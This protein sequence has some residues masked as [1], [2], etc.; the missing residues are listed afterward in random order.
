MSRSNETGRRHIAVSLAAA[1]LVVAGIGGVAALSVARDSH[2]H[3]AVANVSGGRTAEARE[4]LPL[5]VVVGRMPAGWP[6][7]EVMR[8]VAEQSSD[9][10]A[11]ARWRESAELMP[12]GWPATEAMRAAAQYAGAQQA[13]GTAAR[14]DP[15]LA[16]QVYY[17]L[18]HPNVLPAG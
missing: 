17:D 16:W 15:A 12:A 11:S 6:A 13:V 10:L 1:A 18:T 9:G 8:Q 2:G 5:Q 14:I 4:H 3:T 7:T